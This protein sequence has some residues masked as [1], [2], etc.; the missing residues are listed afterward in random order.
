MILRLH[1]ILERACDAR[2][3]NG[4]PL[5]KSAC[6]DCGVVRLLDRRRLG[7]PCSACSASRRTTHG[8]CGTPLFKLLNNV[9]AR[10]EHKSATGY[11]YYGGRGIVVCDEWRSDPRAFV[12]W[13]EANG[14]RPGLEL[15]RKD[16]DGPYSPANCRFISHVDNSRARR[17]SR[18]DMDRAAIV[19]KAI[20]ADQSI[21]AAAKAASV[22]YMVAWHINKG[23]TWRGL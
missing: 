19:R 15:D 23:N 1:A 11:K 5:F 18:C 22:P 16:V 20:D 12:S 6:P 4:T 21:A 7:R 17:N 14:Y 2:S 3:S 13:A 9:R 10:C 8:L